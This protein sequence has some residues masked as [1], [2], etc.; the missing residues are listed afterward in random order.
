MTEVLAYFVSPVRTSIRQY[1]EIIAVLTATQISAPPYNVQSTAAE[2]KEGFV[3]SLIINR[4]PSYGPKSGAH[5][6]QLKFTHLTT[7]MSRISIQSLS[8]L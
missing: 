7:A 1:K 2:L 5:L 6:A 3:F 8:S 4:Y